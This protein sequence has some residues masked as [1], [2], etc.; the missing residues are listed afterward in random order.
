MATQYADANAYNYSDLV[1]N[2]NDPAVRTTAL[3]MIGASSL[4]TYI[5][6]INK[7]A[8]KVVGTNITGDLAKPTWV[9]LNTSPNIVKDP[10]PEPWEEAYFLHRDGC[11]VDDTLLKT[12][13]Q[14]NDPF[15]LKIKTKLEGIAFDRNYKL[16]Q[17]KHGGVFGTDPRV[18]E[19]AFVGFRERLDKPGKYRTNPECLID[20]GG[21]NLGSSGTGTDGINAEFAFEQ[22]FA[23]LG[24]PDGTDVV[25]TGNSIFKRSLNRAVKKSGSGGGFRYDKDAYDRTVEYFMNA[26]FMDCGRTA[27][28]GGLVD[29]V[30]GYVISPTETADGTAD[31]GG[32]FTSVY[33]FKV[34][35]DHLYGWEYDPLKPSEPFMLPDGT[36][37][38]VNLS[39]GIGIAQPDP[40]A[41][42]RIFDFAL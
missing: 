11:Q 24:S 12:D 22:L 21:I 10:D 25:L 37:W 13:D 5:P 8:L 41:V 35:M 3:Y 32:N 30:Q 42:G 33:G 20:A 27:P 28:T 17:N 36:I 1:L 15:E 2:S 40:R 18:D 16:I 4:F 19:N 14:I 23:A 31:T 9:P 26:V 7:R 34:G 6:I 38:Q 29:R 39:H